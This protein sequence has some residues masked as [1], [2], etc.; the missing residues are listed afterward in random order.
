M[1]SSLIAAPK[2]LIIALIGNECQVS[3]ACK[4]AY[5]DRFFGIGKL[6]KEKEIVAFTVDWSIE[7][8][9]TKAYSITALAL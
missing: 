3:K 5:Q 2:R 1:L 9:G 7:V 6:E 8:T 4:S